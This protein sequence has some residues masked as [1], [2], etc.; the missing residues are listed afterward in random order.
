MEKPLKSNHFHRN[1]SGFTLVGVLMVLVIISVL[2]ISILMITSNFVKVST[3]ERNDQSVFYIAEAGLT[4]E[5][6]EIENKIQTAYSKTNDIG[7]FFNELSTKILTSDKQSSATFEKTFENVLPIAKIDVKE[8]NKGNPTRNYKVTST[9]FI[10]NK[11]R[12]LEREFS[13]TWVPKS[14][15]IENMAA[16]VKTTITMKNGSITGSIGTTKTG[17]DSV[18]ATGGSISK[19]SSIYVPIGSEGTAV[20]KLH[21]MSSIPD[22]IG[23]KMDPFPSLPTF[24]PFPNLPLPD[25]KLV[26]KTNKYLIQDGNVLVNS[27]GDGCQPSENYRIDLINN[28][29]FNEIKMENNCSLIFST[30][31]SDKEI[32]VNH[33]NIINGHIVLIGTGKLAIYV[34]D[35]ITMGS[36][37]TINDNGNAEKINIY[38]KG[39]EKSNNAKT[40]SLAGAQKIYGSLYAEDADIELAGGGGFN[41]NLFTGGKSFRVSGGSWVNS[42]LLFAPNATFIHS[43]GTINGKIIANSYEITGG[44]MLNY[45][46]IKI[47]NGPISPGNISGLEGSGNVIIQKKSLQEK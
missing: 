32:V 17:A 30:G 42:P 15:V 3:G 33:L 19:G 37:A 16:Y 13:V 22:A 24:P 2:G 36:G 28:Q 29:Q 14:N 38:L 6:D 21:W 23:V 39:S 47:K 34:K 10:N 45:A 8:L 31:N 41:G 7:S 27:N 43:N 12:V 4:V 9:G 20:N 18:I 26:G 35:N 1:N 40:F 46:E 5:L 25:N 44:A 11:K